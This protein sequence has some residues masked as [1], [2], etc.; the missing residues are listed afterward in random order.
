[1]ETIKHIFGFC[2]ESHPNIFTLILVIVLFKIL[3]YKLYKAKF[4][5]G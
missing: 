1:M 3:I 2:G 5:N 4:N